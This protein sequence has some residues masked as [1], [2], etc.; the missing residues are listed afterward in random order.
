MSKNAIM[1]PP[2]RTKGQASD[3]ANT[4]R[5]TRSSKPTKLFVLD[6]NVLGTFLFCREAAKLMQRHR[7]GRIINLVTVAAPLKLEGESIYASSKAAVVS[8]TEILARE[9]AAFGITVNAVG[10]TAV[11]TDLIDGVP[12]ETLERLVHRQAIRRLAEF[13][14]IANVVDFFVRPESGFV[15]GQVIYLGGIR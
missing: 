3:A 15:T 8:L 9:L 4:P 1:K 5:S 13:D 14:D 11:R 12:K 10:P 6:T 7:Y 2:N